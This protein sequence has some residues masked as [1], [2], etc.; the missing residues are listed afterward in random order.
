M[1]STLKHKNTTES[2]AFTGKSNDQAI[3][4]FVET[5]T[6]EK[7]ALLLKPPDSKKDEIKSKGDEDV[8]EPLISSTTSKK[9]IWRKRRRNY[10]S[11]AKR[12]RPIGLLNTSSTYT[13]VSMP[14]GD[15]LN[16]PLS[17]ESS[18]SESVYSSQ[19][20]ESSQGKENF[21]VNEQQGLSR[22]ETFEKSYQQF[23]DEKSLMD[24]KIE[25]ELK[26]NG[27]FLQESSVYILLKLNALF[28]LNS[29]IPVLDVIRK[30]AVYVGSER[31][32]KN[33]QVD[34]HNR[35][36]D[37]RPFTSAYLRQKSFCEPLIV[38]VLDRGFE[39]HFARLR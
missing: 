2:V 26:L 11:D 28:D 31:F 24:E 9:K 19:S 37:A 33:P 14:P 29:R 13:P 5:S 21:V 32:P 22:K 6:G 25:N 7:Q 8:A 23:L 39:T 34:K 30:H 16:S 20:Q 18:Q 27:L 1:L 3:V 35:L 36:R 38:L 17:Q 12:F 15:S 10:N 4:L